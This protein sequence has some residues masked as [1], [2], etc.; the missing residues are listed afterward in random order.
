[1]IR[2]VLFT[3]RYQK[4]AKFTLLLAHAKS[5]GNISRIESSRGGPAVGFTQ[6]IRFI[7]RSRLVFVGDCSL[8]CLLVV[9]ALASAGLGRAF[10]SE[11]GCGSG[12]GRIEYV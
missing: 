5:K 12:S 11:L 8:I 3:L 7:R 9:K 2:C 10:Y 6:E 1:M 4:L